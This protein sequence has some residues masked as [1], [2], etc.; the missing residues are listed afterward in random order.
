MSDEKST[1]KSDVNVEYRPAQQI[2]AG[3]PNKT[4]DSVQEQRTITT[5][6]LSG[7]ALKMRITTRPAP[8]PEP[9]D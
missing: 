4:A 9:V 5:N 1:H 8:I 7:R 6:S 2:R 3:I